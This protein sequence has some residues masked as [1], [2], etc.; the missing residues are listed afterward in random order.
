MKATLCALTLLCV[1]FSASAGDK[2]QSPNKPQKKKRSFAEE[3]C[4]DSGPGVLVRYNAADAADGAAFD[5]LGL[6]AVGPK[7][8]KMKTYRISAG[9]GCETSLESLAPRGD[10]VV[11]ARGISGDDPRPLEERI[12]ESFTRGALFSQLSRVQFSDQ[13]QLD[14]LWDNL[15]GRGS[16]QELAG[17]VD[18]VSLTGGS[19]DAVMAAPPGY[20]KPSM[21]GRSVDEFKPRVR[22]ARAADVPPLESAPAAPGMLD[23]LGGAFQRGVDAVRRA[24]AAVTGGVDRWWNTPHEPGADDA[25]PTG[26]VGRAIRRVDDFVSGHSRQPQRDLESCAAARGAA[27]CAHAPDLAAGVDQRGAGTPPDKWLR[28]PS[29]GPG[30]KFVR[31]GQWGTPEMITGL[32]ASFKDVASAGTIQVGDISKY[33]GGPLRHHLSHQKGV[34]ADVFFAGGTEGFNS[35]DNA[36][37][38]LRFLISADRHMK[39]T[40]VFLSNRRKARLW[41]EAHKFT[42]ADRQAIDHLF[43][44]RGQGGAIRY[45]PGHDNHF[46][47]RIQ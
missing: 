39:I 22:A 23:R 33:G 44:S 9:Q 28:L 24:P 41:A 14:H 20:S 1:A 46:H 45:W 7:T 35:N 47:I 16:F 12:E 40:M 27:A 4:Q 18:G 36:D 31:Y 26:P 17:K 8:A 5:T 10:R 37:H 30:F 25:E 38:N 3:A 6:E 19:G 43:G 42:G 21:V 15:N 2:P 34:D 29:S 11:L 32:M 13:G